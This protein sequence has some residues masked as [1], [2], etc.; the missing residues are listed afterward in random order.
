M[1]KMFL[2]PSNKNGNSGVLP[3]RFPAYFNEIFDG[4]FNNDIFKREFANFVPAVNIAETKENF[5]IDFSVPGFNKENIK[6]E[7]EKNLLKVSG[8][9]KNESKEEGKEYSKKEFNMGSFSRSFNLPESVDVEK[10]D[11]KYTD[12]ILK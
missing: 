2:N 8:E 10:I 1:M 12:G 7:T 6:I 4:Y 9:F 5:T 11:A 3:R